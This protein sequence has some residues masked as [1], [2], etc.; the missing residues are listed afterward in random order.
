MAKKPLSFVLTIKHTIKNLTAHNKSQLLLC[1]TTCFHALEEKKKKGTNCTGI[2]IFKKEDR[3]HFSVNVNSNIP[4]GSPNIR[5][6]AFPVEMW[7]STTR[8]QM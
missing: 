4:W 5:N 7:K 6:T 3:Q 2:I 8:R 1:P